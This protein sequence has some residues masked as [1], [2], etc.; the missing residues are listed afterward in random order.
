[1]KTSAIGAFCLAAS[2]VLSGTGAVPESLAAH[3]RPSQQ[4]MAD[5]TEEGGPFHAASSGDGLP[6]TA[7]A[8][9]AVPAAHRG[10]PSS[11]AYFTEKGGPTGPAAVSS[12]E[13]PAA[14]SAEDNAPTNPDGNADAAVITSCDDLPAD[15]VDADGLVLV[16]GPIICH[17][18]KVRMDGR[19]FSLVYTHTERVQQTTYTRSPCRCCWSQMALLPCNSLDSL[20]DTSKP[21]RVYA[22]LRCS[23]SVYVS[24]FASVARMKKRKNFPRASEQKNSRA[25]FESVRREKDSNSRLNALH[26]GA[27]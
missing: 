9:P 10:G 17:Q 7:T 16:R 2:A 1:M 21:P 22:E 15:V 3:S 27:R 23:S 26:S 8:A 4:H 12:T 24:L 25:L 5:S 11:I 13:E 14:M 6:V 20:G 18:T 19:I